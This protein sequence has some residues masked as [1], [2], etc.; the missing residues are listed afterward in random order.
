MND[1]IQ[2]AIVAAIKGVTK[3]WKKEKRQ[4]DRNDRVSSARLRR[5]RY[6]PPRVT[7]REV[8]FEVMEKAY[9]LASSNGKYYAN[10]RQ[11]MYAARPE[12]LSQCDASEFNDVYFTQT[13]LRGDTALWSH[14]GRSPHQRAAP[15]RLPDRRWRCLRRLLGFLRVLP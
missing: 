3:S 1:N 7:I 15:R 14:E 10:A 11:I 6:V 13:L 9:N 2:A 5:M 8:A 4:A 12:I